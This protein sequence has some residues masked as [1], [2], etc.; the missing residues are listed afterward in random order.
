MYIQGA[1]VQQIKH[2][3][4][5]PPASCIRE[6]VCFLSGCLMVFDGFFD[7]F[8]RHKKGPK[9][10]RKKHY[11]MTVRCVCVCVRGYVFA[12]LTQAGVHA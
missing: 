11:I 1:I 5:C 12:H 4:C 3:V 8:F 6:K 9:K 10:N 2:T 7:G